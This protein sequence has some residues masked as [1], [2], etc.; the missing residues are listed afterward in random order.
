MCRL[1]I[2]RFVVASFRFVVK[3][4]MRKIV[5]TLAVAL[6]LLSSTP[7]VTVEAETAPIPISG[8]WTNVTPAGV[9]LANPLYCDNFGAITM[10]VDPARQSN[11][12]TQ[13]H[14]SEEHTS[15]LQSR[16]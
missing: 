1:P 7:P 15:E 14:R 11:L 3:M 6:G 4:T 10:M 9:D 16:F 2:S 5:S 13:F 12:Y 8:T